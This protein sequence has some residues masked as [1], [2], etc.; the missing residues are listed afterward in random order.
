M[1]RLNKI[2]GAICAVFMTGI[3]AICMGFPVYAATTGNGSLVYSPNP[4]ATYDDSGVTYVRMI[5]LKHNG[6]NNGTMLCIFDQQIVVDGQGVWPVY[7]ST[8]SGETWQHVTDIRDNVYGTTHKMNPCIFELP[9][10]VGGMS[11]GTILVAGLLIP[12]DWSESQITLFQSTDIGQTFTSVGVVDVGGPIDYDNMPDATTTTIW[13]PYLGIDGNGDL[14]CYYSDER[15][16]EN[17]VLQALVYRSSSDGEHW[18]KIT[19]VVAVPNYSDRPGMITVTK[20]GNGKYMAVYEVVNRP[21]IAVN[22]AICYYKISDD[23]IN[24]NPTDLGTPVLLEDGTGCGSAPFVKWIDAGGPNGMVVIVPK[25]QVDQNG[26][27][28]G[29]QNFFVN[30]NY[31]EGLW[32]R[33]PMAVTFDGPNTE[34]LLS[35]FSGSIDTNV[36]GTVLYQSANV[37]NLSTGRNEVRVGAIPLTA[38]TYEAENAQLSNVKVD[39]F[40]DASGG[41]KVGYINY[42]DSSVLFD[43]ITVP[44]SGT[45]TVNVRYTNGT[46]SNAAHNVSVN[47]GSSF[48]VNY[49]PTVKWGRYQWASFTCSLNAGV[50]TIKFQTGAGYAELDCIQVFRSGVD[51]SNQFALVNRNSN[52]LLEI[53]GASLEDNEQ[54]AQYEWTNYNCQLWS[55]TSKDGSYIQLQNVNSGKMLEIKEA[56]VQDG[57]AA[58]QYPASGNYCQDWSLSPS[59]DGYYN[60]IN[61]NS[62][63]ML[64]VKDNLTENGALIAQWGATGYPCQEWKLIKEGTK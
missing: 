62:Q 26:A 18:G 54:A 60:L 63:K 24:W 33:M 64:E 49:A 9:Q 35:G 48:A 61:R 17:G 36:E 47:N 16:K 52:K 45:Y 28:Q 55:I 40:I 2:V 7:K 51:L 27:I 8:D 31:G 1:M 21:S 57:A 42:S 13:E 14:A 32:E 22:T 12:D 19:N 6:A 37:E 29:G 25:W 10:D 56:S 11:E 34:N 46:G 39:E 59:S 44:T 3:L 20:M 41:K 4:D 53:P 38:A 23:G 5:T 30:Y 50:N 43:K 58:V 15:Q